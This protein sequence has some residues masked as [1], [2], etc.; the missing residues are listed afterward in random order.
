M[1][2]VAANWQYNFKNHFRN[3]GLFQAI[4]GRMSFSWTLQAWKSQPF[5]FGTF[6]GLY[7]PNECAMITP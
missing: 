2:F 4:P 6:Q 5:N 1:F 7:K 3:P